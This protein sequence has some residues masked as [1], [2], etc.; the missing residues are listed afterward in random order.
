MNFFDNFKV[1]NSIMH[2]YGHNALTLVSPNNFK[3]DLGGLRPKTRVQLCGGDPDTTVRAGSATR[4][5]PRR[6]AV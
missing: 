2:L 3:I 5:T 4:R 6:V 1:E